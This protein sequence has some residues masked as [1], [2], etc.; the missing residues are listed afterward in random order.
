[1]SA[2]RPADEENISGVDS[3]TPLLRETTF[4]NRNTSAIQILRKIIFSN[5]INVMLI[6]LPFGI[7]S[8]AIGWPAVLT[9]VFNFLALLALASVLSFATEELSKKVG[10]TIS[11]LLN[12]SFGNA[13]ELIV[14]IVALKQGQVK[15]VQASMLGSILSS[16]LL[17]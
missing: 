2:R 12:T 17:V 10:Q 11:G 6:F 1:M 4:R 13:T 14:S 15:L 7:I 3:R 9:F 8:G 5:Y 16:S